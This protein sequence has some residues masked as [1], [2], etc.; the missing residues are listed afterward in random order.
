MPQQFLLGGYFFIISFA[1]TYLLTPFSIYLAV[2]GMILDNPGP[3]KLH[4][5]P[6]PLLG[7]TAIFASFVIVLT[8]HLIMLAQMWGDR[9]YAGVNLIVTSVIKDPNIDYIRLSIIFGG[10]ILILLI[11]LLD[12][13][14]GLSVAL[15]LALEFI[16]S[17]VV[18][19]S[20]LRPEIPLGS[21]ITEIL[22]IIWIVGITN[23]FN[24]LDGADGLS[25]GVAVICSVGLSLCLLLKWAYQPAVSM[26]LIC[27]AGACA[28]FL[29][30][31]FPRAKVFLGSA[32]SMFIGYILGVSVLISSL[33]NFE[34]L[35][36]RVFAI[37]LF[38][39]AIPL[40]DTF[41]V[42]LIR[43]K[44][45]KSILEGD[46]NHFVHRLMK[47]GFSPGKAVLIIYLLTTIML[48]NAFFLIIIQPS[49]SVIMLQILLSLFT[50][51]SIEKTVLKN[52]SKPSEVR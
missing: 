40:Y 42:I 2:K 7:G 25:C 9:S 17:T 46:F 34:A 11:G 33:M 16:I 20:G 15:R 6:M 24:L 26:M 41:S 32:G 18:V 39:L 28:G 8:A 50:L 13:M 37:P 44:N 12:D 10:G 48:C 31:N 14:M 35:G 19:L 47:K 45:K 1:L 36:K 51:L 30:Y 5:K 38:I 22:A 29:P 27:F 3:R 43:L 21:P 23:S 52:H 49:F 4:E